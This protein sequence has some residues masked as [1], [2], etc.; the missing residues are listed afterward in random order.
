MKKKRTV[1]EL[2]ILLRK[3]KDG[4]KSGLCAWSYTLFLKSKITLAEY[5]LLIS[6]IIKNR[7]HTVKK[8]DVYFWRS[9]HIEPRL[10]W[11]KTHIGEPQS[12]I[13]H[14]KKLLLLW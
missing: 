9:G 12:F 2:L 4:F 10:T 6:F 8:T 11:I 3:H 7:P 14:T 5:D 13:E 1:R